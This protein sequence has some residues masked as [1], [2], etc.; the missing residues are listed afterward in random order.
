[1]LLAGPGLVHADTDDALPPLFADRIDYLNTHGYITPRCRSALVDLVHA[2]ESLDQARADQQRLEGNLPTLRAQADA[3]SAQT[4]SLKKELAHYEHP[5]D[6]DF[7]ALQAAAKNPASSLEE[8]LDLAQ[9]FI[10]SYPADP[11]Q[12]EAE[13]DLQQW[14]KQLATRQL[15]AADAA[16]VQIW[17][18]DQFLK[19]AMEHYLSL[20]EW[21]VFLAQMSQEDLLHYLG[22][23]QLRT[24]D[25]WTY[26][27]EWTWDPATRTR[28]GMLITFNGTRVLRVSAVSP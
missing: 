14:Q 9:A 5:E 18:H 15:A 20:G 19:R 13:Q 10:W 2:R 11:R 26:R 7:I 16:T 24:S 27:G 8:K 28:A 6:D 3:T 25:S 4:E 17:A 1:M 22:P 21:Q 12:A 23:P